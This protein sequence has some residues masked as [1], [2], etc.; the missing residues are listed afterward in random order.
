[1]I[2]VTVYGTCI[3]L[4]ESHFIDRYTY[5]RSP[6]NMTIATGIIFIG[7]VYEAMPRGLAAVSVIISG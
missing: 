6:N 2:L 4:Q 7:I 1:M 3:M 5:S